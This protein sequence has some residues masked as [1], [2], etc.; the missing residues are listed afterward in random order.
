MNQFDFN[1]LKYLH[2]QK[3]GKPNMKR[4]KLPLTTKQTHIGMRL[5]FKF[6]NNPTHTYIILENPRIDHGKSVVKSRNEDT[7]EIFFF[8]NWALQTAIVLTPENS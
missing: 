2:A 8:D 7:N 3:N 4:T 6:L 5:Q 1:L